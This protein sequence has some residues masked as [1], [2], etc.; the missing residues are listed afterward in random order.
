MQLKISS[1]CITVHDVQ[2]MDYRGLVGH[3]IAL[4]LVKLHQEHNV[5]FLAFYESHTR[6]TSGS[7]KEQSGRL[8]INL[9]GVREDSSVVADILDEAGV[10]LQ[11]PQT[12]DLTV[13]YVNPHYLV[14]PN[15][16]HPEAITGLQVMETSQI[17]FNLSV[18]QRLK[19]NIAQALD[20]S[21]QGPSH[22]SRIALSDS[23][24]TSLKS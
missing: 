14:R 11:H 7:K 10:Y 15:G 13:P 4:S 9:Y 23:I 17:S 20:C 21:A 12:G 8:C 22:Y 24:R 3:G 6:K 19:S 16:K 5:S 1:H 18:N 2:T